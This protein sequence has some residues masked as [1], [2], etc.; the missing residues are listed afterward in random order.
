[1]AMSLVQYYEIKPSF[2]LEETLESLT[3]GTWQLARA[4][5]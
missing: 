4:D 5:R 3:V 1:M 2:R